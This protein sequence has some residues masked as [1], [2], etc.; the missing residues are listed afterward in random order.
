MSTDNVLLG[1]FVGAA[2]QRKIY[3]SEIDKVGVTL[4]DGNAE[5]VKYLA[6]WH[7]SRHSLRIPTK[8]DALGLQP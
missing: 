5:V 8:H 4:L 1:G 3:Q 7:D 2:A 6:S